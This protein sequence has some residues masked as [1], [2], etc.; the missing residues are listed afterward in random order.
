MDAQIKK[1]IRYAGLKGEIVRDWRFKK[2]SFHSVEF[3]NFSMKRVA[4][5]EESYYNP[6][7]ALIPKE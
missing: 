5:L 4:G 6:I 1:T 3:D 2:I 7:R